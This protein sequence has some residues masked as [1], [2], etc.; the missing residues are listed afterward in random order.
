M[1]KIKILD[2]GCGIGFVTEFALL[3]YKNLYAADLT[4]NALKITKKDYLQTM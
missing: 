4:D 1:T 2:L 3:G